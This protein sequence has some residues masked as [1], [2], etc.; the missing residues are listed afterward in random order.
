LLLWVRNLIR[1]YARVAK[2]NFRFMDCALSPFGL[3]LF[4]VLLYRSWFQHK[5]LKQVSWKGRTYAG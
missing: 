1:F 4:A 2:S 3:P 5:V